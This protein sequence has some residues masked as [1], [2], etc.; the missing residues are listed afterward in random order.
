MPEP[1]K[2]TNTGGDVIGFVPGKPGLI[3]GKSN[4]EESEY[5]QEKSYPEISLVHGI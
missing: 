1:V 5:A 2:V 4:E 3:N